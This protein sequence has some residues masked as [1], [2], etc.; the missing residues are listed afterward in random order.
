MYILLSFDEHLL[1]WS[2]YRC[3]STTGIKIQ[4]ISL[5][6]EELPLLISSQFPK[7]MC[8]RAAGKLILQINSI[9]LA[10][11]SPPSPSFTFIYIYFVCVYGCVGVCTVYVAP[12]AS[13]KPEEGLESLVLEEQVTVSIWH[14]MSSGSKTWVLWESSKP[15]TAAHLSTP[16]TALFWSTQWLRPI[17]PHCASI[18]CCWV[19]LSYSSSNACLLAHLLKDVWAVSISELWTQLVFIVMSTSPLFLFRA[20]C[21]HRHGLISSQ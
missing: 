21:M 3:D 19:Y 8:H 13:W 7:L 9:T 10:G 17:H 20:S 15:S 11:A 16:C 14:D 12:L 5:I 2:V 4:G 1:I 18:V 6:P